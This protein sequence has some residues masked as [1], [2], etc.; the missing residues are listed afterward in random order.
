PIMNEEMEKYLGYINGQ[1]S[2]MK[3]IVLRN[4]GIKKRY[5]ALNSEG[6][7][8]H[9]NAQMTSLA[10][11]ELA[12]TAEIDLK[13]I[14]LIACGTSSPDQIMP[15]HGVMVHGWLPESAASEVITPSGNCCASLHALKYAYLAIKSGEVEAAICTGSERFSSILRSDHYE[16]EIEK[17]AQMEANPRLAFEKDF[18]R[19]MLSDGACAFL[20]SD[21]PANS[22]TSLKIDWLDGASYAH[23]V[24]T[25]MYMGGEK[26]K[27]GS[28][29]SYME[30]DQQ[31]LLDKSIF[32]IK[33]DVRLLDAN[34]VP[35]GYDKLK[36]VLANKGLTVDDFDYFL[37]HLSSEY[38]R[39]KISEIL[40]DNDMDIPQEKWFTNLAYTGNVGAA[41]PFLMIDEMMTSGKLKKGDKLLLMVPES[42]RFSYVYG[43]LT[44]V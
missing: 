30:Y 37:P 12:K 26:E 24:E 8:T 36:S 25:C 3:G 16:D 1:A 34:I 31:E 33:Q 44:V 39:G 19:W 14:P 29:K 9:T 17:L 6:K 13:D 4:N 22:G 23:M 10:I 43:S 42:A 38:F 2:K 40:K 11:R 28:L 15:S 27:D 18:L 5:Y 41:S 20:L 35:Y 7:V 32:T 21:K